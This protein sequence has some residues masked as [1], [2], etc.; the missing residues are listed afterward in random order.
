M[1]D[2]VA[3][4]YRKAS[5]KFSRISFIVIFQFNSKSETTKHLKILLC[6]GIALSLFHFGK[7]KIS[8]VKYLTLLYP[9]K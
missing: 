6:I 8:K 7:L 4:Y 2:K 3:K 9:T 5:E 1:H